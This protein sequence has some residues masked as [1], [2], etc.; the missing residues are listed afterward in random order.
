[1]DRRSFLATSGAA[2]AALVLPRGKGLK[3]MA[4]PTFVAPG[5]SVAVTATSN[6]VLAA[7]VQLGQGGF[8]WAVLTNCSPWIITVINAS[9]T[10][11][12]QPYS[13]DVVTVDQGQQINLTMSVPTGGS[14]TPPVTALSYVQ[15]DWYAGSEP[16]GTFPYSL[17]AQAM[18]AFGYTPSV[19]VS[20]SDPVFT[21]TGIATTYFGPVNR[22]VIVRHATLAVGIDELVVATAGILYLNFVG[23]GYP[24]L[25]MPIPLVVSSGAPFFATETVSFPGG[26][27]CFPNASG[28]FLI[29]AFLH[30]GG[31]ITSIDGQVEATAG[32]S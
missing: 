14:A 21:T 11:S 16:P 30:N 20:S 31:V 15:A 19:A 24:L 1:M 26:I 23:G 13:A 9:G 5:A 22:A 10:S 25:T 7:P 6:V 2:S 27:S 17:T 18:Q 28:A 8:K 29:L 4:Q 3:K 12:V 32:Y